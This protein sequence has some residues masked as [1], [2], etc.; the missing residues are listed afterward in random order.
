MTYDVVVV[1][2][3]VV[4]AAIARELSGCQVGGRPLRVALVDARGDVGD[5]TSKANTAILHTGFDAPPAGAAPRLAG[6]ALT[7]LAIAGIIV[8]LTPAVTHALQ[9]PRD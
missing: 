1:G 6:I 7:A 2:A 9:E 8:A 5:A 4:G 3:G